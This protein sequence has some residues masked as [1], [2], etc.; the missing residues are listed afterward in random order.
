MKLRL[1]SLLLLLAF[2]SFARAID[3]INVSDHLSCGTNV[4]QSLQ[5]AIETTGDHVS[6]R[7]D[8]PEY[9]I[10]SLVIEDKKSVYIHATRPTS[11][12]LK[13][14]TYRVSTHEADHDEPPIQINGCGYVQITGPIEFNGSRAKFV[15]PT[16]EATA[17]AP[18]L[19]ITT[20]DSDRQTVIVDGLTNRDNGYGGVRV[21]NKGGLTHGYDSVTLGNLKSYNSPLNIAH[22]RGAHQR[23]WIEKIYAEDPN[24]KS[25]W[26]QSAAVSTVSITAEVSV[27]DDHLGHVV[28]RDVESRYSTSAVGCSQ[29]YK[30]QLVENVR[31]DS[32][33]YYGNGDRLTTYNGGPATKIDNV[34]WAG[35]TQVTIRN[36]VTVNTNRED[37]YKSLWVGQA[38]DQN[39]VYESCDFD[40]DVHSPGVSSPNRP[41]S[42]EGHAR[43]GV[44]RNSIF[45]GNVVAGGTT[46]IQDC[47]F[48]GETKFDPTYTNSQHDDFDQA[49]KAKTLLDI[50][51][52]DVSIVDCDWVAA[53]TIIRK[54][55]AGVVIERPR[56]LAGSDVRTENFYEGE[57][58]IVHPRD[59]IVFGQWNL[60][61]NPATLRVID[62][63]GPVVNKSIVDPNNGK[64]LNVVIEGQD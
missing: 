37:G 20:S 25:A 2:V 45:R 60:A 63:I 10:S 7:L 5:Q 61:S 3:V 59:L 40:A 22:V 47:R 11:I 31:I 18:F 12:Y 6:L 51:G 21:S 14:G 35:P 44:I 19:E 42:Q 38:G 36:F 56:Y 4:T 8:S 43:L 29:A 49:F 39:I 50:R 24:C 27:P 1:S 15:Q 48:I 32:R 46:R 54:S 55:A 34:F 58:T 13:A 23:V 52:G 16:I 26:H 17:I 28:I 64:K 30:S 33:G 57:S 9:E 62:P 53:H 41:G